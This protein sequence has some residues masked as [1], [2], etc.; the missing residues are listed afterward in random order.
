MTTTEAPFDLREWMDERDWS[1]RKL[2]TRLDRGPRTIQEYIDG[3]REVPTIVR[4]ALDA[5]DAK[6]ERGD[7][8]PAA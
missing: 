6:G 7:K 5:L 4:L 8:A 2:A 1:V 3:T